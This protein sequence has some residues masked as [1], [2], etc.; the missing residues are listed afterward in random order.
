M[1]GYFADA[2][3]QDTRGGRGRTTRRKG[4]RTVRGCEGAWIAQAKEEARARPAGWLV[5][6]QDVQDT[7]LGDRR[8][9]VHNA[10]RFGTEAEAAA[11]AAEFQTGAENGWECPQGF[12]GRAYHARVWVEREAV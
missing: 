7:R 10:G 3:A 11:Y 8:V 5:L 9:S 4:T 2:A 12:G 6:V 1:P